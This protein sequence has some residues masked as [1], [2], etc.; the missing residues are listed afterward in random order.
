VRQGGVRDGIRAAFWMAEKD[1]RVE[2]RRPYE[3]LSVLAF[4][5]GSLL[6]AGILVPGAYRSAPAVASAVIWIILFFSAILLCTTSFL[7]EAERGTL[8]GLR[9]LPC[10]PLAILAGKVLS[11]VL[12]LVALEAVLLLLAVPFLGL[13]LPG[14]MIPLSAVLLLGAFGLACSGSFVSGLAMFAEG[15]TLI[16][17][18]LLL[19]VSLP[20]LVLGGT[21]TGRL[22]GSGTLADVIPEL[23]L[24]LAYLL[25]V[26][27]VM[28]LTFD[29]VLEE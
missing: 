22:V 14:S 15:K 21:A 10:S 16:I 24:L 11:A 29:F 26:I 19:P 9:S 13:P 25:V 23:T 4:A 17:S 2:F 6:L 7:R 18:L 28:I 3:L 12:L 5:I 20:V 27:A 8:G 1:L